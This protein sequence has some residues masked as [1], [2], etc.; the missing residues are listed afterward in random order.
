MLISD[1]RDYSSIAEVVDPST[2]ASML[3]DHRGAMSE[4]VAGSGGTVMDFSGDSVMAVFGAPIP[5]EGHPDSAFE[6]AKQMQIRQESLNESW[7]Q[8]GLSP[9]HI[10]IGLSTGTVA[11]AILGSEEKMEYSVV[12]DSVNLAQRLQQWAKRGHI[13]LSEPT[14]KAIRNPPQMEDLGMR[15]VKGKSLEVRAYRYCVT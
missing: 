2:L 13:I 6:A 1:V 8:N 15:E 10:G 5:L 4:V 9:F 7:T 12:G 3:N 11:A 14:Y